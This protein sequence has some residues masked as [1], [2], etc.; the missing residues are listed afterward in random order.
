MGVQVGGAVVGSKALG[1]LVN[2]VQETRPIRVRTVSTNVGTNVA[3]YQVPSRNS[4]PGV[5]YCGV[6]HG[7]VVAVYKYGYVPTRPT[8]IPTL[9]LKPRVR[10]AR[11]GRR[12]P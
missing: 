11:G 2:R 6:A 1:R 10:L 8:L 5:M 3:W 4:V 9:V 12:V 7:G